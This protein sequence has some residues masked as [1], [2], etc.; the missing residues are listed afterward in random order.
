MILTKR[1]ELQ[2]KLMSFYGNRTPLQERIEN[3]KNKTSENMEEI[4]CMISKYEL[5]IK[6]RK[7]E[8][9]YARQLMMWYLSENTQLTL[10][11]IGEMF[12]RDHST[13]IHAKG[14][15][16]DFIQ[17]P[18]KNFKSVVFEIDSEL[19]KMFH[20]APKI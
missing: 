2:Y 18:D 20:I 9:V 16:N 11:M 12:N 14:V 15:V 17:F 3:L 8:L 7:R 19:R 4:K 5:A 10:G 6:S 1:I 13:V